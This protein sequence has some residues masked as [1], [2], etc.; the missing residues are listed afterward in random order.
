MSTRIQV[1]LGRPGESLQIPYPS[2]FKGEKSDPR[3]TEIRL[4]HSFRLLTVD[5]VAVAED[6]LKTLPYS[7]SLSTGAHFIDPNDPLLSSSHDHLDQIE[8]DQK[9]TNTRSS[10]NGGE[11]SVRERVLIIRESYQ[12]VG[13]MAIAP[14]A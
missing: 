5:E 8:A 1:A 4:N 12:G 6:F 9:M 3:A 2:G 10:P 11:R 14:G 13:Q 7:Q